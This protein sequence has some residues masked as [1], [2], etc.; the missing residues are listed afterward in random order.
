MAHPPVY[1]KGGYQ[2]LIGMRMTLIYS[3]SLTTYDW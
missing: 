3:K 2:S 1:E